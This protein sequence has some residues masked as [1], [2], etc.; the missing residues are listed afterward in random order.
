M[1]FSNKLQLKHIA[2]TFKT[3]SLTFV[4]NGQSGFLSQERLDLAPTRQR[5]GLL[6]TFDPDRSTIVTQDDVSLCC[7]TTADLNKICQIRL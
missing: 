2:I 6:D 4:Q 5:M 3:T 1:Y 7:A